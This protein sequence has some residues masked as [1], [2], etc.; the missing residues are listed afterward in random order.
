MFDKSCKN[1]LVRGVNWIGD[2]VMTMPALRALRKSLPGAK[3]S[4]LVRP[5]V[6]PLFENNPYIDEIILYE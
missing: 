2:A 1:L 5:W 4:L 3:I 6:A